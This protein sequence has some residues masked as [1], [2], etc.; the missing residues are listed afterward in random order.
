MKIMLAEDP[1]TC[2]KLGDQATRTRESFQ[3]WES[4]KREVMEKAD[5]NKFS[6]NEH[7]K[8]VLLSTGERLLAEAS[9]RD[10]YWG[11]GMH[12]SHRQKT[13]IQQW[14]GQNVLGETLMK[15]RNLLRE[16]L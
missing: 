15:V 6:Q 2:K 7:L 14:P 1:L 11:I 8:A 12:M 16:K 3:K 9:P 13:D 10:T 4:H 5:I